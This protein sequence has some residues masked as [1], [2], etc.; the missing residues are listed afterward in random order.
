[1][2]FVACHFPNNFKQSIEQLDFNFNIF[3]VVNHQSDVIFQLVSDQSKVNKSVH[4]VLSNCRLSLFIFGNVE[5]ESEFMKH[6]AIVLC[7]EH[8][9]PK[10]LGTNAQ[11]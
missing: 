7:C 9:R 10:C 6:L 5:V 1:M 4:E 8:K 11:T 2:L 3:E